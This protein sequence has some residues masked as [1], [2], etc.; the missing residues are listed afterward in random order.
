M[1]FFRAV[2]KIIDKERRYVP[3]PQKLFRE[4]KS[5]MKDRLEP[6]TYAIGACGGVSGFQRTE[7]AGADHK[8]LKLKATVII[9]Q[10]S[11]TKKC[12]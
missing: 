12:S 7:G 6:T 9:R 10:F 5:A 11:I 4:P 2:C 3:Q 1:Q 8:F